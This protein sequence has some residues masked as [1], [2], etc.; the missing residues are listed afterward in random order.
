[1]KQKFLRIK[2]PDV[3]FDVPVPPDTIMPA[4]AENLQTRGFL[5]FDMLWVPARSVI[6]CCLWEADVEQTGQVLN[7][8]RPPE[9][10]KPS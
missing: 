6:Y 9:G 8:T 4:I 7:F 10:F 5:V 1:M 3:Q 2:V